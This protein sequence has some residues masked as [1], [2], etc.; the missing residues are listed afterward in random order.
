M[1][2]VG[3]MLKEARVMKGLKPRDIEQAIKIREKYILAIE[4]DTFDVMPSPSY[5]KG[6]VRNYA[7]YL[8]LPTDAVMAFFRRQTTDVTRSS[9]L[10]KGVADPLNAPIVHL[11]P[12]RF[13]GLIVAT[14]CVIFFLYLGIQYFEIG[15]APPLIV[16]SP[17]NQQ[18]VTG[19]RVVVEGK[20]APDTTVMI[21]GVSTIVR[22]DGRFYEQV[23]V[24]PGV[25]KITIVAT[26]RFG[27][28]TSETREVGYQP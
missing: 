24:E 25:N 1:K 16:T 13:I 4:A 10:P 20:T 15:K 7:E 14:L 5:A 2:T 28:V 17:V 23:A 6:F 27:K 3:T 21:N 22:D 9:L 8:G 19:S 11:T 12:G 26:T 18:I